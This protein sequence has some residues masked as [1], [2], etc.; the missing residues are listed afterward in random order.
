MKLFNCLSAIALVVVL[1]ACGGG[2]GS[3]GTTTTGS[4][5]L[6]N[7]ATGDQQ[8]TATA[9]MSMDVFSGA[10]SSTNSISAIEISKVQIILKDAAGKVVPGVVVTF[11][12]TGAGLL[13]FAP[14]SSTALTDEKGVA[15]IEIRAASTSSVGATVVNASA[16]VSGGAIAAQKAIAIT[17]APS[18]GATV[19]DPQTLANALNFLDVNPADKAIVIQGAGGNGRS[20][21]ATLRFRIVDKN[22]TPV[23]GVKATFLAVPS[24]DV[25]LNI[26]DAKSDAEGVVVTTVSSKS[27][28][29]AVVIRATVT[30]T[31]TS[32]IISQSDQ[33][34]VTTGVATQ[35]GFD[36]AASKYNLNF[37]LTG[38]KSEI[39]VRIRDANG[40]PVADGVPVVFTANFGAV[41]FSSRG[42]CITLGGLCKVDYIV[43]NPRPIDGQLAL[44]TASTQ[45]GDGTSISDVLAF[46][47]VNPSLLNLFNTS[48]DGSRIE[49]INFPRGT[50]G[51][52][53]FS[54]FAG[55]PGNFPAPAGTTV[56]VNPITSD[57]GA[58]LKSGS[59]ILDQISLSPFRTTIDIEID[60]SKMV[61][62]NSCDISGAV[63]KTAFLDVKFLADSLTTTRRINVNYFGLQ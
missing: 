4:N 19:P 30:R 22:N 3:S 43:Q 1:S 42:G 20:E 24:E 16:T 31:D 25:T 38:D 63:A 21:S 35:A 40:N 46:N 11:S 12:E 48:I 8:T 45:V 32:T 55:T 62:P 39:T 26:T 9:S 34:V 37:G 56:T 5:S 2:G 17:N 61:S 53:T 23:Q 49:R 13:S 33:L 41:G 60:L 54:F 15:G 14:T 50:C 10:G 52:S 44:V 28:A 27:K 36:L 29:T 57:L 7:S 59:P 51:K 18:N 47:F 6:G 58:S